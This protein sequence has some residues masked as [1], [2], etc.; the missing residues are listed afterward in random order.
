MKKKSIGLVSLLLSAIMLFTACTAKEAKPSESAAS[1]APSASTAASTAPSTAPGADKDP[2]QTLRLVFL[3]PESLDPAASY[4]TGTFSILNATQEGLV[5]VKNTG[6]AD[7]TVGAGAE[8]WETSADGLTW[9]FHLRDYNWSDGKPVTAQ[10]FVDAF[11]RLL[12][13]ESAYPYAYF[14]Y[15]IKNGEAFNTGKAK[16]EDVGVKALDDKTLEIKLERP[17]PFFLSKISYPVFYPVRLDVIEAGGETWATDETKQVYSGPFTIKEWVKNN[18]ITLEKNPA[19]WD[20]AN[21]SITSVVMNDIP[22]FSTQAQLFESAQLDVTGSLQEYVQKWKEDAAAG[23]FVGVSGDTPLTG[24]IALNQETGGL[25]GILNNVKVRKAI[26][27]AFDRDEL[28]KDIYGRYSPAYGFI[29]KTLLSGKVDYRTTVE[30]PLKAEAANYVN[31]P[32]ELQKLLHEGLKE[33]GKDTANLKDI[34]LTFITTGTGATDKQRQEW[35][36]QQLETNL[37]ISVQM[38]VFGDTKLYNEAKNAWKFDIMASGWIGDYNDPL[39]FLDMWVTGGGNN[40]SGYKS[41]E[42]DTLLKSLDN[43][44]DETERLEIYKKLE[45]KLVAEDYAITPTYYGD[46]QRFIQNYVKDFGFPIFG[47]VYDWRW[48]YIAKR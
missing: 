23:K 33:I 6:G 7:E 27:L 36:Q 15:D 13:K 2:D 31:K 12:V 41:A 21:V 34:K 37:G 48:A 29:P 10:H 16:A 26:S 9:T 4:D 25:S 43:V 8:S 14:G 45:K 20:A 17:V 5:R 47:P 30:E 35:W 1:P 38:E 42:Y 18:S 46:T 44:T 39:T 22:E 3:E 11:L 40:Y 28:T 32:E 24:F 19:Y